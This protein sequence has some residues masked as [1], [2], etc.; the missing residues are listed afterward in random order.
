MKTD[1]NRLHK[2][3]EGELTGPRCGKTFLQCHVAAGFIELGFTEIICVVSEYQD[4]NHIVPMLKGILEE[5]C[6]LLQKKKNCNQFK[7]VELIANG[8]L[9]NEIIN[10]WIWFITQRDF[11]DPM[12]GRM[13]R[14][15]DRDDSVLILMLRDMIYGYNDE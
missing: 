9:G 6:F 7:R 13:F 3:A 15:F 2:V 8:Y 5:R 14:G 11:E 1:L 12:L 4:I 10:S